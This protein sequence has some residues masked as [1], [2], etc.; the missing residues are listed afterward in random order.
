MIASGDFHKNVGQAL[1]SLIRYVLQ[2][3]VIFI[4]KSSGLELEVAQESEV[5]I[6]DSPIKEIIEHIS[7][8]TFAVNDKNNTESVHGEFQREAWLLHKTIWS[9]FVDKQK[10]PTD[11]D[12]SGNPNARCYQIPNF[13]EGYIFKDESRV[14]FIDKDILYTKTVGYEEI[15]QIKS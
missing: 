6:V 14:Y 7:F 1:D 12:A 2:A 10:N 11:P 8:V 5:T 3:Y 15:S 13:K 9:L 4:Q